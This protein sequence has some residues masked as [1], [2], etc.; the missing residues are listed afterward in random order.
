M[1]TKTYEELI[2]LKTFEERFEYLSLCCKVGERT[3]GSHRMLNQ[4]LYSS[5]EWK[6]IR[7]KVILRDNGCDLALDGYQISGRAYIHHINPLT[8]NDIL[9]R[10]LEVFSLNNLVCVSFTTHN[11]IHYGNKEVIV[12]DPVVRRPNDT[13]PWRN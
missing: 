5:P 12:K 2:C 9:D 4:A 7:R 10:S 11:A 3:F 13:C 6:E 1:M 8:E